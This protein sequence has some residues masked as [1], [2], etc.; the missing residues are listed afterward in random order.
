M[1]KAPFPHCDPHVL[2][3][4]GECEYCDIYPE[5][6]NDRVTGGINFTGHTDADKAPCPADSARG[7]GHKRWPG[8]IARPVS[9]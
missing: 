7:A 5:F 6:Q 2:H 4:P 3:A 1:D 8:N 9:R